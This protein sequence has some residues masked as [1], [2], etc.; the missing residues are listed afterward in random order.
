[1]K[2]D[3]VKEIFKN[4]VENE[5]DFVNDNH[6]ANESEFKNFGILKRVAQNDNLI[7]DRL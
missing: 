6:H 2:K 5:E 4:L 3:S 7:F 1:M